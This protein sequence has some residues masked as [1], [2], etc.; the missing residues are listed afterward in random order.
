MYTGCHHYNK[1]CPELLQKKIQGQSKQCG[2]LL[3]GAVTGHQKK[4]QN[5]QKVFRGEVLR[6]KL[7]YKTS[8]ALGRILPR[9]RL[10]ASWL[11]TGTGKGHNGRGRRTGRR[12]GFLNRCR[13]GRFFWPFRN[14]F[15]AITAVILGNITVIHKSPPGKKIQ[16]SC[17]EEAGGCPCQSCSPHG[18]FQLSYPFP[19]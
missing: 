16:S 4:Q 19:A 9:R 11:G 1:R 18:P 14:A 6:Q 17:V 5:D 15:A 2:V 10:S 3:F 12:L 8:D 7:F 13:T